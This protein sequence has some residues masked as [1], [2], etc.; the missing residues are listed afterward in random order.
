MS[1]QQFWKYT[2]GILADFWNDKRL[3]FIVVSSCNHAF[4]GNAKKLKFGLLK[5]YI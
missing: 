2:E 3:P 4:S 5:H 1:S